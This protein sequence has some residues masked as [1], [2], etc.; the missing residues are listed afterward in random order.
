MTHDWVAGV[1]G[2]LLLL[3]VPYVQYWSLLNRIDLLALVLSWAALFVLVRFADRR[4][5]IALAAAL[6]TASIFT[7]QSYALAAP[8]GGFVWLLVGRQWRKALQLAL[9]TGGAALG[10]FLLLNLLSWGGFYLNVVTANVNPFNWDT[11]QYHY[12]ELYGNGFFLILVALFFSAVGWSGG[13]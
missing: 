12:E 7:R 3:A 10:L 8:F 4:W 2:G 1:I 5:G 11:V 9:I 13:N 6:L